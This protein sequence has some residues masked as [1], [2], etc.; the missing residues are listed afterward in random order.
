VLAPIYMIHAVE[1]RSIFDS[2]TT[3]LNSYSGGWWLSFGLYVVLSMILGFAVGIFSIPSAFLSV[4]SLSLGDEYPWIKPLSM[5]F[6]VLQN[7]A[8]IFVYSVMM[9]AVFFRYGSLREANEAIAFRMKVNAIGQNKADIN[10]THDL[11]KRGY[12]DEDEDY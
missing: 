5:L 9:V 8:N 3:A 6:Q 10:E 2:F 1:K 11:R 7:L 12:I 4:L